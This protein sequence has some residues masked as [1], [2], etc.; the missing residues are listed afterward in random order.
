M[1]RL[2][3]TAAALCLLIASPASA[4]THTYS[5]GYESSSGPSYT[6]LSTFRDDGEFLMSPGANCTTPY[7]IPVIFQTQWI[8]V[9]DQSYR[10]FI[11]LGTGHQ[12]GP[13][14][15]CRF[16]YW[17]Y[18]DAN[19]W[20]SL[21]T[22]LIGPGILPGTRTI[23]GIAPPSSCSATSRC[24][25]YRVGGVVLTRIKWTVQGTVVQAGLESV[26]SQATVYSHVYDT[27][28]YKRNDGGWT[29]WAGRDA[30]L[31]NAPMCGL[32]TSSDDWRAGEN[33]TC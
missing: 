19:G 26:D 6:G 18:G 21:G 28:Q 4:Q 30:Q 14:G 17:G 3:A 29:A 22:Q 10:F 1:E 24:W 7:V 33:T 25:E 27:L 32:W 16:R 20:H 31:V 12:N 9:I 5:T 13:N 11:E 23:L 8:I 2:L 15:Y